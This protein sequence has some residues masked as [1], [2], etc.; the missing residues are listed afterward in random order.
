MQKNRFLTMTNLVSHTERRTMTEIME[1]LACMS[2]LVFMIG[3]MARCWTG[4][5][6]FDFVTLGRG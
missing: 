2:L 4:N 3:G 5:D 6:C 1:T